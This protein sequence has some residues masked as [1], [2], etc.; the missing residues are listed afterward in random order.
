[1]SVAAMKNIAN[2]LDIQSTVRLREV[3]KMWKEFADIA[4]ASDLNVAIRVFGNHQD[5][6]D[7]HFYFE[8]GKSYATWKCCIASALRPIPSSAFETSDSNQVNS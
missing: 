2:L 6:A 3:N 5:G 8:S 7:F 4:I 1:Y